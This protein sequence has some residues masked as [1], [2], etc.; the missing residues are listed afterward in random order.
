MLFARV[1]DREHS[2]MADIG[3]ADALTALGD[4][5]EAMRIYARAAMRAA[6]LRLAGA[7]SDRRGVGRAARAR[8]RALPRCARR[9][10]GVAPP[11]RAARHAAAPG[12]RGKA[13]GRRVSRTASAARSA[14]AVRP[15]VDEVPGAGHARR[16]G[17]DAGAARARAGPAGRPGR[18]GRFAGRAR[19]A[20]FAAQ[21]NGV[22]EA[23]VALAR[24]ELALLA[25][26]CRR[27]ARARR[28]SPNGASRRRTCRTVARGPTWSA[29]MRCC[30]RAGWR[31]R[32]RSSTRRSPG[33]ANCSCCPCRSAA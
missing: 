17:V 18:R 15:G 24:A 33:R 9:L 11:L 27:G 25:W 10:R 31:R 20:A 26:R 2:V 23:A 8:A 14:R 28:S 7:R 12:H 32:A 4:F 6:H 21:G 22:G 30:A 19:A 16:R 29:R 1:G 3:L 13:A 5:D